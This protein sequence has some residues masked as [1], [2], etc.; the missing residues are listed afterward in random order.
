MQQWLEVTAGNLH[1][2][3]L[4][5]WSHGRENS[6]LKPSA[7]AVNETLCERMKD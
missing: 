6:C 1:H 7:A 4:L 5:P 2:N 3:P